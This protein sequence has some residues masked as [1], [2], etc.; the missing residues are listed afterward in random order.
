MDEV[1]EQSNYNQKAGLEPV[2]PVIYWA[3]NDWELARFSGQVCT[4]ISS[5]KFLMKTILCRN[6]VCKPTGK[7][8]SAQFFNLSK[9]EKPYL[10][11]AVWAL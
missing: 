8:E 5:K 4:K 11:Q 7:R 9:F 6:M 2:I 1:H 10:Q 3:V